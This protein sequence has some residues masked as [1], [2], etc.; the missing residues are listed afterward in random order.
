MY[1]YV[2]LNGD[3]YVKTEP[4]TLTKWLKAESS[5]FSPRIL[6]YALALAA[7]TL[8]AYTRR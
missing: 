3:I 4:N 1:K 6:W 5:Q 2:T 8:W 7:T